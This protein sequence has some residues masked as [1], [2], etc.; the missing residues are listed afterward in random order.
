MNKIIGSVIAVSITFSTLSL[1]H[2]E[3]LIPQDRLHQMGSGHVLSPARQELKSK[4]MNVRQ[5]NKTLRATNSGAL[6]DYRATNSGAI[7]QMKR[8]LSDDDKNTIKKAH[9]DRKM[10][11][12]SL[13]GLS[14]EQK[15]LYMSGIEDKIRL[16]IES[17]Y[18]HATGSLMD[19]RMKVYNENS[20][21]RS[22]ALMNQLDLRASRGTLRIAEVD[23][24]IAK[25]TLE[26]PNLSVEKKTKLA[27]KLDDRI[28][29]I[30]KNKRIPESS[31]SEIVMKL[32]NLRN[33]LLK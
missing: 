14:L 32:T 28:E 11:V 25:V 4:V 10:Y 15:A 23:T 1:S 27:K 6:H 12:Q 24:L 29:K 17:R 13:S 7:R 16:E 18:A 19:S 2:A 20:L 22:E 33:E 30:Q 5:K 26:L 31:K 21:R 3:T 9:E 8:E